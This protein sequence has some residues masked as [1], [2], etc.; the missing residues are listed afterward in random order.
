MA[1]QAYKVV[2]VNNNDTLSVR[3]HPTSSSRK[4]NTLDYNARD[5]FL[6]SCTKIK[7]S[8]WCQLEDASAGWVNK[9]YL[10][11]TTS[12]YTSSEDVK[13]DYMKK[14]KGKPTAILELI[15]KDEEWTK[16]SLQGVNEVC[17][18][19][20]RAYEL[21]GERVLLDG[22]DCVSEK[23]L[24][25]KYKICT[26]SK[27][28]CRSIE[29]IKDFAD[30]VSLSSKLTSSVSNIYS[31]AELFLIVNHQN[32][33]LQNKTLTEKLKNRGVIVKDTCLVKEVDNDN[34]LFGGNK[35]MFTIDCTMS[36]TRQTVRLKTNN[37]NVV[38]IHRG[39]RIPFV[40]KIKSLD[41]MNDYMKIQSLVVNLNK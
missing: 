20:V 7:K 30:N 35:N 37:T 34:G 9:R 41:A 28:A 18:I 19:S 23:D 32:T 1:N 26:K 4:I 2:G 25:N 38:N 6:I 33:D 31:I 21:R 3:E 8:T 29:D 11:K 24:Q 12:K 13:I 17:H 22:T 14:H 40:G 10:K 36:N 16:M 27:T 15:F 5:I 39:D